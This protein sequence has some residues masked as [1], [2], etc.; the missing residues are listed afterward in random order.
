[1]RNAQMGH[2]VKVMTDPLDFAIDAHH[3]IL[4]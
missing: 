3:W 4:R 1:V 2:G